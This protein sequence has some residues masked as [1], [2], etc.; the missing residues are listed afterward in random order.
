MIAS[1][2]T[3]TERKAKPI[4]KI[5]TITAAESPFDYANN[6]EVLIVTDVKKGDLA[7]L[8][9]A[10]ARIIDEV[11]KRP[12]SDFQRPEEPTSPPNY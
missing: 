2:A 11:N 1:S 6:A 3:R 12:L 10:Y 4:T 7:G 9:G 8:A 5:L